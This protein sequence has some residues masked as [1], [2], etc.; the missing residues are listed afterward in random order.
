[1]SE[2][3]CPRSSLSE[4]EHVRPGAGLVERDLERP[5]LDWPRLANELVHAALAEQAVPVLVDVDAVRRARSLA[6]EEHAERDRVPR[7]AVQHEVRVARVEAVGDASARLVEHDLLAPGRPLALERPL[8][9]P[10]AALVA[11]IRLRGAQVV[12]VGLRLHALPLDGHE[13]ALDAE[14]PLDHALRL[15]VAPLAE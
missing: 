6:V 4:S 5:V 3:I 12:P 1:M 8:A 11:E 10:L 7:F 9:R 2:R 14:Q 13:L 15:L